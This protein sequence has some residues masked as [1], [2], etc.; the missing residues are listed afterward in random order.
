M[1]QTRKIRADKVT[2]GMVIFGAGRV[3]NITRTD[4]AIPGDT[5]FGFELADG[6]AARYAA[7]WR[8]MVEVIR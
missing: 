6:P 5:M 8:K 1:S 2:M 4:G 3:V 7:H